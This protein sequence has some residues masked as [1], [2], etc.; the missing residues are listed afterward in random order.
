[1]ALTASTASRLRRLASP[2]SPRLT[3]SDGNPAV[4][5]L[6]R[7]SCVALLAVKALLYGDYQAIMVLFIT[8]RS[9]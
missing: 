5:L 2:R 6:L 4:A 8:S 3:A 7:L 9:S 1:M